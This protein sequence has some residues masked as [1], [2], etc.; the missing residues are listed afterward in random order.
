MANE[1]IPSHAAELLDDLTAIVIRACAAIAATSPA[2]AEHWTKDDHSP[3]T[4]A[5][6]RSEAIILEGLAHLLPEIPV[7]SEESGP[8]A[9]FSSTDSFL[10]VDPLDGT[11]EFIAGRDEFTVN[12]AVIT[13]GAPVAGIVA[14][15]KVGQ[16]WRGVVGEKAER[17]P[18]TQ[19]GPGRPESIRTR[20]WRSEGP[21]AVVSRSH[22]DP[23]SQSFL[24]TLGPVT[25]VASGS[26]IKFCQ[27]AEGKADV[28]PRL[29]TTF[30]WDVAAGHALV[31]AAGGIVTSPQGS[32]LVYGR[33]SENFRIPAFIAWGDPRKAKE[34]NR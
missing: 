27:L 20:P 17:L 22:L 15:P 11:R 32:P 5:D 6:R 26:A 29:S 12:L 21:V 24:N 28:Y 1:I 9:S 8:A 4:E 2:S 34:I 31:T 16:I 14:A 30:E 33:A 23:A 3:V 25:R 10:A 7:V 18:F 13:R 19:K